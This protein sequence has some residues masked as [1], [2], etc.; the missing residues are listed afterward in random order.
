MSG[1]INNQICFWHLVLDQIIMNILNQDQHTRVLPPL[2]KDVTARFD[3]IVKIAA[4]ETDANIAMISQISDKG[5]I[6]RSVL[7][8]SEDPYTLNEFVPYISDIFCFKVVRSKTFLHLDESD[9]EA[10]HYIGVPIYKPNGEIFGALGIRGV[11]LH[12]GLNNSKRLLLKLADIVT[13]DLRRH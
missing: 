10:S 4:E 9:K 12:H 3:E 11:K 6:V 5:F 8:T 13:D 7:D 2:P 1:H